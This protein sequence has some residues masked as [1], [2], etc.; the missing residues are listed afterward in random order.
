[1]AMGTFTENGIITTDRHRRQYDFIDI[2]WRDIDCCCQFVLTD[3]HE[4]HEILKQD[5]TGMYRRYLTK[6]NAAR[7]SLKNRSDRKCEKMA[8]RQKDKL[9]WL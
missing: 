3:S 7:I 5:F 1:M 6:F 8:G 9:K 4:A 2:P